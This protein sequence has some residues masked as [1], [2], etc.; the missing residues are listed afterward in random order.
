M[1]LGGQSR[2]LII[3]SK[4]MGWDPTVIPETGE[5]I[6]NFNKEPDRVS[7]DTTGT[8]PQGIPDTFPDAD[9]QKGPQG[10]NWE[11]PTHNDGNLPI[12]HTKNANPFPGMPGAK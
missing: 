10:V 6:A 11:H 4:L 8:L 5:S 12:R 7:H 1:A 9:N 3:A 2:A